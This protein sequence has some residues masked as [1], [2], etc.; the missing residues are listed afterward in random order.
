MTTKV[1]AKNTAA[2]AVT[3]RKNYSK[4]Q[5]HQQTVVVTKI[6]TITTTVAALTARAVQTKVITGVKSSSHRY[7]RYLNRL[8][9]V[10]YVP[11][12]NA[13]L[14]RLSK[15]LLLLLQPLTVLMKQTRKA[16]RAIKQSIL[17][18]CLW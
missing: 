9:M 14:K 1:K 15:L 7:R 6:A 17:L 11:A 3:T 10:C 18:R 8:L 5:L 16:V 13:S 2:A 4:K 12:I